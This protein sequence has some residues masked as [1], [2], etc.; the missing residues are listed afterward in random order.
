MEYRHGE[1]TRTLL[2]VELDRCIQILDKNMQRFGTDFPSAC[3]I[4]GI[5]RIKKNDDWTNGFWTGMLWLGW[6]Y[7]SDKRFYD[8][9]M[10]NVES[11]KKRLAEHF[12]LDHH[13]IG[14]L[15]SLSVVAAWKITGF[16][17]LT[18]PII[19]A[20]NLL[21]SRF[22]E[23]GGFIQA[24]GKLGEEKEYRLIIDSLLNLPLLYRASEI[25]GNKRYTDIA[26]SHYDKVI[27]N[28]VREDYSTYHTFYFD[29][30]TGNPDHGATHQG[31]SDSSCWARGQAWAILGM[32]L[33]SRLSGKGFSEEETRLYQH[34]CDY[35][36]KH[37]PS[38][39]MPYWDLIF[40]DGS[41][42]PRDS[43][44]LAIAACGMLE[45]G[46]TERAIEMIKT[47]KELA[48]SET[49]SS[50]EGLILHGVYAY[51]EGKGIDEPN[52]WG[53]YFYMEAL[54]RLWNPQW[55]PFW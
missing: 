54:Y 51:A 17:E 34:I 10:E 3:A 45:M 48:S 1:P 12:I 16:E 33:H 40:T 7:T 38:D 36:E 32:P 39:K 50:S 8:L 31:F 49:D 42:Q 53:D 15:Y 22:Q 20:A 13:D 30:A 2:R 43:S 44:A 24:W 9:A 35:F 29:K 41:D 11:F 4:D 5:Y 21:A 25:T 28:I 27:H 19:D 46:Q 23:K 47:I 52:L 6:L 26:E 37:L 18:I 55:E 14:F